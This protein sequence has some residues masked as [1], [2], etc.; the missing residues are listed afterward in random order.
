MAEKAAAIERL[1]A[2][3]RRLRDGKWHGFAG[4]DRWFEEPINNAKLAP[5]AVY[6]DQV[7]D[8]RRLLKNCS[9]DYARFYRAVETYAALDKS[10]RTEAL[11]AAKG[12][13]GS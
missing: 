6:G 3:Y 11:H 1:R 7:E 13:A 5:I 4:Y 10:V 2:R 12:C 8:F 9:G